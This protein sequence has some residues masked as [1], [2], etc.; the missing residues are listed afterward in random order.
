[1]LRRIR[2]AH[3]WP[4]LLFVPAFIAVIITGP[5]PGVSGNSLCFC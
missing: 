2:K 5:P 4:A 3:R 1:M